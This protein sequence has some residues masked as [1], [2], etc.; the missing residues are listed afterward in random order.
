MSNLSM[1]RHL[2]PTPTPR[3]GNAS[4]GGH[5]QSLPDIRRNDVFTEYEVE[6]VEDE[7]RHA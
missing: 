4:L 2:E 1:S 5:L 7:K 3:S 6:E